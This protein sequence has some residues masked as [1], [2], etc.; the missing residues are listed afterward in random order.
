MRI[1]VIEDDPRTAS[2]LIRAFR[3]SGHVADGA[4]DGATGLAMAREGVYDALVLDRLLPAMDG[5]QLARTLR[6]EGNE[7]PILMLSASG[8]THHRVEGLKSGCDDYLSKPYAFVEVLARVEGLLAR[9]APRPVGNVLRVGDLELDLLARQAI[10][11]ARPISLNM[12]EFL[13]LERLMRQPGSVV[14]RAMLLECAWDYDFEP[15]DNLIDKHMHRLRK[16]ID[17]DAAYPL[18]HTARGVGYS[19]GP[20]PSAVPKQ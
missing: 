1:L 16:K 7:I 2:Y 10:R 6:R 20:V 17:A 4:S 8:A 9:A 5:L 12:R 14:T 15:P 19:I 13:L 18:I 3:E 11:D